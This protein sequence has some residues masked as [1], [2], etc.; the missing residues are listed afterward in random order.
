MADAEAAAGGALVRC[1]LDKAR[2][3]LLVEA[4]DELVEARGDELVGLHVE[5]RDELAEA[6]E[7]LDGLLLVDNSSDSPSELDPDEPATAGAEV[8]PPPPRG[9]KRARADAG[10]KSEHSDGGGEEESPS[11]EDTA[12]TG[13]VQGKGK[14][15]T[16]SKGGNRGKG[17]GCGVKGKGGN[18]KSKKKF[19]KGRQSSFC[20][21]W[22]QHPGLDTYFSQVYASGHRPKG[23]DFCHKCEHMTY[24]G[25]KFDGNR[26]CRNVWCDD[27]HAPPGLVP[28][29]YY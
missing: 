23:E 12:A 26:R 18:G 8:G 9:K 25:K 7:V 17:K 28:Y 22:C 15:L 16:K 24:M 6:R 5:V 20:G 21:P 29:Y 27:Y 2:D 3:D 1:E 10:T 4:R 13:K 19:R 11:G 14:G